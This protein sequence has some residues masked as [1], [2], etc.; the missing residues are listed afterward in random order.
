MTTK[1]T[2]KK[3]QI[4]STIPP[5]SRSAEPL[6]PI[7]GNSKISLAAPKVFGPISTLVTTIRVQGQSPGAE[8]FVISLADQ[9]VKANGMASRGDQRFVLLPGI[10][11]N[12]RDC[13]V[14]TQRIG[15]DASDLPS[16]YHSVFVHQAPLSVSEIGHVKIESCYFFNGD[17]H[18]WVSDCI[19]GALVEVFF[20]GKSQGRS[21]S[22][23][24]IAR[25]TFSDKPQRAAQVYVQQIVKGIG[26]G[27][28]SSITTKPMLSTFFGQRDFHLQG[29]IAN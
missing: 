6:E 2:Y 8:V 24:G 5:Y 1:E 15:M 11:L 12:C 4:L 27:P 3:T 7:P 26:A 16:E 29:L 23:E 19:P 17:Y 22:E 25:L 28:L 9:Q 13:L 14:A 21:L 20:D 10:V 18:L